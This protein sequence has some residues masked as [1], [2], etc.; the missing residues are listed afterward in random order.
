MNPSCDTLVIIPGLASPD[1]SDCTPVY[2]TL[3]SVAVSIGG[4]KTVT[5][6][7][8]WPGQSDAKGDV[9]GQLTFF[10]AAQRL[11]QALA[12]RTAE[13]RPIHLIARSFGCAVAASV[14]AKSANADV[15]EH[16]IFWGPPPYWMWWDTFVRHRD[17]YFARSADKGCRL[18]ASFVQDIEPIEAHAKG[19]RCPVRFATGELDE[20]A[21]PAA[22]R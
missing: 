13:G 22:V 16:A 18:A 4:Y 12:A 14:L 2:R 21:A 17:K 10:G 8:R 19:I 15:C 9:H 3:R 1:H 7:L 6:D 11:E 20:V 5:D